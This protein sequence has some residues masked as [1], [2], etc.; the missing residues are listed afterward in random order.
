MY[1]DTDLS[2]RYVISFNVQ[3]NLIGKMSSFFSLKRKL[4]PQGR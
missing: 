1:K 3:N 2:F 4:S